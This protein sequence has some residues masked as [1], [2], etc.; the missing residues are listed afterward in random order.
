MSFSQEVKKEIL[1][2]EV[3]KG[4]CAIASAYAV[5]CFGKYFDTHGIVLHTE[6]ESAALYAKRV[7]HRVGIVGEV[8]KRGKEDSA[9]FEFSVKEDREV[10]KMLFLFGHTGKEATLRINSINF[11]CDNC[12]S[13]FVSTA[14][15]CC[16][17]MTNPE[18]E[19]HLEFLS[20]RYNLMKD[21]E[22]LL[23]GHGFAPR[24]T[25]RK[26]SNVLYLKASE[27]I[28]DLLTYMGASGAALEIMNTKVYKDFRNKANRIT[29]CET[30]NIDK[31]VMANQTTIQAI[32]YLRKHGAFETLPPPLQDA[33]D[34]RVAYPDLSLKEL[35]ILFVPMLSKS[36]LAHRMKKLE[37]L[38]QDMRKG[39]T[40]V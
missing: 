19:Y 5:A 33:A 29:N 35:S 17:T 27:Q 13:A 9:L 21:F 31:T 8:S 4:C 7:M 39:K 25:Q 23:Q 28:E 20:N 6:L 30:A 11:M 38:A 40:N 12:V 15:L 36:G 3:P 24:H 16:G 37:T 14:F 2:H 26:G 18:L 1:T 34:M 22:A 32:E 10:E